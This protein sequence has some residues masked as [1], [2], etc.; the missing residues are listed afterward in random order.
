MQVVSNSRH[1][2]LGDSNG[3]DA[4]AADSQRVTMPLIDQDA[5]AAAAADNEC[6]LFKYT[7]PVCACDGV[8]TPANISAAVT[9][10][11]PNFVARKKLTIPASRPFAAFQ[12]QP[13]PNRVGLGRNSI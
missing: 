8:D 9:R 1:L 2:R 5:A 7:V 11:P 3:A 13:A 10:A 4:D 12:Y 6:H